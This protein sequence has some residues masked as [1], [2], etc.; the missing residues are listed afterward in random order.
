[1][2]LKEDTLKVGGNISILVSNILPKEIKNFGMYEDIM[3]CSA[4]FVIPVCNLLRDKLI[5][6]AKVEK[7]L[8]GKDAKMEML[9]KY[10]SSQEFSSKINMM[11]DVFSNLKSGIDSERRA[12]EK[13]WKKREK[14]IERATFAVTGM[15]G[16]LE[17]LM[18]QALPGSELLEL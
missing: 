8:E 9:Y 13:N 4:D 6:I 16:E 3:V 2:K 15:Y 10:L 12:M 11:V 7:T 1:M 14:D 18:G 5:S 17:S